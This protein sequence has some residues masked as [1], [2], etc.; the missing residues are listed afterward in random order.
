MAD[1]LKLAAEPKQR[2]GKGAARAER[3]AGRVPAVIYGAKKDPVMITL[4]PRDLQRE[5]TGGSFFST[6]YDVGVE[7]K[8]ERVLPRDLQLHP[9]TDRPMHVDFLRVSATTKVTVEVPVIFVNDDNVPGIKR[10]GLLNVV[11]YAVEVSCNADSIPGEFQIDL[12]A[13]NLDIGD[14]VHASD[15]SLP[16]GVELTITDRDFTIATI[17]APTVVAEE[18]EGEEAAEGEAPG[19]PEGEAPAEAP[20][21]GGGEE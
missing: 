7:G 5:L 6:I 9:V 4:E 17:A 8:N 2:A 19:A 16:E 15:L 18:S 12:E 21:E 3:R 14:S 1:I 13:L 20:A 11:R 10:G